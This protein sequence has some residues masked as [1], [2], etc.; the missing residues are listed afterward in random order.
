MFSLINIVFSSAIFLRQL[1]PQ[2]IN[3]YFA[4]CD[5]AVNI[6]MNRL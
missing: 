5:Y 4:C 6:D 1:F 2:Y 3:T